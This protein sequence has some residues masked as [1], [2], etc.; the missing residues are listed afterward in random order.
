[1][2]DLKF[3][4]GTQQSGL[5]FDLKIAN[6]GKD[7]QIL[8]YSRDI[9]EEILTDDPLLETPQNKILLKQLQNLSEE[10][11]DWRNIS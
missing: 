3:L 2:M 6:L 1:M 5:A 8:Q 10:K 4:E 7:G 9:A 11:I